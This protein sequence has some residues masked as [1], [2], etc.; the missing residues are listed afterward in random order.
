MT[1]KQLFV[2]SILHFLCF[3]FCIL[4]FIFLFFLYFVFCIL[5][6]CIAIEEDWP[7]SPDISF[8]CLG[9]PLWIG[10]AKRQI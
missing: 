7:H 6:I 2:F 9:F 8:H 10:F 4:Y 1:R 3:E 5:Y